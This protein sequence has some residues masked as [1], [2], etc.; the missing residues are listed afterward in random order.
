MD[1]LNEPSGDDIANVALEQ[2]D[3]LPSKRKPLKRDGG[4]REWIPLSAIVASGED[5]LTCL[6]LATGMKCLPQCKLSQA[7]GNVLHDWHA[8]I[9]CLRSLNHF[10]LQE[11][12]SLLST[13]STPSRFL[14][15]RAPETI[16]PGSFQPFE[17]KPHIKLFLYCSEAPCGDASMELTMAAQEDATPWTLPRDAAS[18]RDATSTKTQLPGRANFQLL[19]RVRRKP[20]RPDAPPTLSKSCSDK[21]AAAQ[22]TSLLSSITSLFISPQNIYLHSMILPET[23][24]SEAGFA[25]CF[26]TRLAAVQHQHHREAGLAESGYSFHE[27]GIKTTGREFTYSRRYVSP[28]CVAQMPEYV[29]SN[30]STSWINGDGKAG[31]ETLV[32]GALQG[33]K[34]FDLRGGSRVCRRRGWRLGIEVLGVMSAVA[35]V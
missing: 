16:T 24:Y 1:E 6:A 9:L 4:V 17:L 34:Q 2:F 7:Q 26:K 22:Y 31:G 30:V 20:S 10:L 15:R 35:R 12:R 19:G 27:M 13:P 32:N 29:S 5:G 25:R 18:P 23:Q 14:Q 21:L 28:E 8:E 33:R 3:E 11:V